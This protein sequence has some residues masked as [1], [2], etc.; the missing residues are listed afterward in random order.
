[1]DIFVLSD[2]ALIAAL[3][4]HGN[5]RVPNKYRDLNTWI[6]LMLQNSEFKKVINE[7][8]ENL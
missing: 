2:V 3:G 7:M 4:N 1:M 8:I 5:I 6:E